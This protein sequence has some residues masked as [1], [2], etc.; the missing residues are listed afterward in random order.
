M[1]GNCKSQAELEAA[2]HGDIH[3]IVMDN[4]EELSTLEGVCEETRHTARVMLRLAL[5]LEAETHPSLMTA[6]RYSKFGFSP[7]EEDGV[8]ETMQRSERLRLIGIH[9]HL[10]SQIADLEIYR[11]ATDELVGRMDALRR[12]GLP[13]EEVSIGGGWAVPYRSGDPLL[14][15]EDVAATVGECLRGRTGVRLAVEPGRSVVARSAVAIYRVGSVKRSEVGR[16]V[17]VDGG[18]GDNPRPALYGSAYT[19]LPV[20]GAT[21]EA[22][23]QADVVGRYCESGD[24]LA[25]NVPLPRVSAGDLLFMPVAG[26]YQLSMVS[27]Y[28]RV[29]APAVVIVS[30]GAARV[31]SRRATVADLFARESA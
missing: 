3:A 2:V 17:A 6:G 9:V 5:P 28:N 14:K 19:A 11:R 26:A 25:R 15:P 20:N 27:E 1:H 21:R 13:V 18:M 29:P 7:D 16:I 24:V 23:G 22:D 4:R 12:R 8:W 30:N 31:I 10:G